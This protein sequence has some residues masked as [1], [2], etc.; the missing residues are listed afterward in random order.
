MAVSS[1]WIGAGWRQAGRSGASQGQQPFAGPFLV[2]LVGLD[3]MASGS[4]WLLSFLLAR[5]HCVLYEIR[6]HLGGRS[7]VKFGPPRAGPPSIPCWIQRRLPPGPAS[8]DPKLY[9]QKGKI[10]MLSVPGGATRAMSGMRT[11]LGTA[12]STVSIKPIKELVWGWPPVAPSDPWGWLGWNPGQTRRW[13]PV[14]WTR[15][16]PKTD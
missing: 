7:W 13:N 14:Q 1:C 4:Q 15:R 6:L 12:H 10:Q 5:S 16:V 11:F 3:G 9:I 8:H 2:V